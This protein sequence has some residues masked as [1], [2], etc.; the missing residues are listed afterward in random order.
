MVGQVH[1]PRDSFGGLPGG[2]AWLLVLVAVLHGGDSAVVAERADA[3]PVADSQYDSYYA[4][5]DAPVYPANDPAQPLPPVEQRDETFRSGFMEP[6]AD[7]SSMPTLPAALD[8]DADLENEMPVFGGM[9]G[10]G[11]GAGPGRPG[12][13]LHFGFLAG[14]N[15]DFGMHEM[16]VDGRFKVVPVGLPLM[17][18]GQFGAYFVDAP[19]SLDLP[20]ELRSF[21]IGLNAPLGKY[22]GMVFMLRTSLGMSGELAVAPLELLLQPT[23]QIAV[24]ERL[25]VM[26]S[27]GVKWLIPTESIEA[28]LVQPVVMA[29][30][31]YKWRPNVDLVFGVIY[32]GSDAAWPLLPMAG[33][34]WR[35]REDLHLELTMP[36]PKI[37]YCFA[38]EPSVAWWGY[39]GFG[40][41]GD[42]WYVRRSDDV[43]RAVAYRH[44][45]LVLG[46]ERKATRHVTASLEL[47]YCLGRG[48]RVDEEDLD[49]SFGDTL[50][51][52][53]SLRY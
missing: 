42:R 30:G 44:T 34:N 12:V 36:R 20:E 6:S 43:T 47:G 33:L 5:E 49:V 25:Q 7:E 50:S 14:D 16:A 10:F 28:E 15:D 9:P 13:G 11:G 17:V 23:A 18:N 38:R 2:F 32:T 35:I 37:R 19:G 41:G 53:A 8:D 31:F 52:S 48:A 27:A 21:R 51:V 22:K 24:S 1:V 40:F 3:E 45:E 4:L 26:A 46:I 29:M 39:L